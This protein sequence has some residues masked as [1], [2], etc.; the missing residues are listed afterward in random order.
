MTQGTEQRFADLAGQAMDNL[1]KF[2]RKKERTS[3]DIGVA[4]V[5]T[6]VLSAWTRQQQTKSAAE[7]TRF[8]VAR[9]L[10]TDKEQLAEYIRLTMPDYPVAKALPEAREGS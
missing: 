7:A 5:A 9:E 2:F 4:R 10:A 6:S 3:R 8:M 1:R